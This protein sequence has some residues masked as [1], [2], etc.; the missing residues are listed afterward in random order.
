M[1]FCFQPR[2]SNRTGFIIYHQKQLKHW[3]NMKLWYFNTMDIRQRRTV[4]PDRGTA[5]KES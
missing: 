2:W 1:D 5:N 4:I 3:K